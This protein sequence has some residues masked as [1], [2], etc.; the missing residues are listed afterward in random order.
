MPLLCGATQ[1]SSPVSPSILHLSTT[2]HCGVLPGNCHCLKMKLE[3]QHP[4]PPLM[5]RRHRVPERTGPSHLGPKRQEEKKKKKKNRR[6]RKPTLDPWSVS[7][8]GPPSQSAAHSTCR[9]QARLCPSRPT[10]GPVEAPSQAL[11][12]SSR[13]PGLGSHG[14]DGGGWTSPVDPEEFSGPSTAGS[15]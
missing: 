2:A 3:A 11:R 9:S 7:R 8:P 1:T 12:S 13:S 4:H 5:G 6:N 15:R 14:G 10:A